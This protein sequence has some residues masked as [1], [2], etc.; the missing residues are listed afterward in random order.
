MEGGRVAVNVQRLDG[1]VE[2]LAV[3]LGALDLTEKVLGEIGRRYAMFPS[4]RALTL[5]GRA[6]RY[7]KRSA[8]QRGPPGEEARVRKLTVRRQRCAGELEELAA[9]LDG[10]DALVGEDMRDATDGV[11]NGGSCRRPV[12][13]IVEAAHARTS[14]VVL[15]GRVVHPS[16][17]TESRFS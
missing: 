3:V 16:L 17:A 4:A 6:P 1:G 15:V 7:A 10:K 12:A 11:L 9:N 14:R 2:V 13:L 8:V 5:K